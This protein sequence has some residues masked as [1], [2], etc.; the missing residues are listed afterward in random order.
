MKRYLR[1]WGVSAIPIFV[2]SMSAAMKFLG[3]QSFS[4]SSRYL[5]YGT[6]GVLEVVSVLLYAIPRTAVLGAILCTGYLGGAIATHVRT[7]GQFLPALLFGVLVWLG[8]Y[9]RDERI[10]ALVP[11]TSA[12]R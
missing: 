8:R 9:L 10:R 1:V 6:I 7:D 3:G 12:S 2:L 11:L 4:S 5:G